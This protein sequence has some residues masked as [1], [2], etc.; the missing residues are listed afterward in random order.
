MWLLPGSCSIAH[1]VADIRSGCRVKTAKE[2]RRA[3]DELRHERLALE[4]HR[5]AA[6]GLVQAA[7][8]SERARGH[9]VDRGGEPRAGGLGVGGGP[10]PEERDANAH[11][12]AA[13]R[14]RWT[15]LAR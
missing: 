9:G 1:D 5:R 10:A 13:V 3:E 4:A 11:G 14:R 12:A 2:R 8:L 15:G 7:Q 6:D